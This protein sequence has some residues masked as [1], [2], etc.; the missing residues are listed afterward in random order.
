MYRNLVLAIA[1]IASISSQAQDSNN[2]NSDNTG[3]TMSPETVRKKALQVEAGYSYFNGDV[4]FNEKNPYGWNNYFTT[5]KSSSNACALKLRYGAFERL[6]ISAQYG[7]M[8]TNSRV[9]YSINEPNENNDHTDYFDFAV[10]GQILNGSGDVPA[11]GV[12]IEYSSQP[13]GGESFVR[14]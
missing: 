3:Y 4:E 9:E 8:F 11:V 13:N 5:I 7:T 2:I 12:S 6:E 1:C 14:I 10:K